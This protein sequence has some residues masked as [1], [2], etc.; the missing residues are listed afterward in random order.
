MTKST[1]HAKNLSF[2]LASIIFDDSE[3]SDIIQYLIF[4]L[5]SK[6]P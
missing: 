4:F 1:N 5:P 6:I 2:H 3:L